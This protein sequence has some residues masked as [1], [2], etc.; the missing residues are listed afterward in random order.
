MVL[1]LLDLRVQLD[2]LVDQVQG[3]IKDSQ[4]HKE[5]L[6]LPVFLEEPV[7]EGLLAQM[8]ELDLQ[9][10]EEFLVSQEDRVYK[11]CLDHLAQL[12]PQDS[13]VVLVY[14]DQMD[15]QVYLF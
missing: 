7:F 6:E 9:D 4:V 11:V 1:V 15:S 2:S 3:V 12:D 14:L 8:V 13:L 10:Q 5:P